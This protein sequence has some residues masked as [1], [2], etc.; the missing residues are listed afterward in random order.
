MTNKDDKKALNQMGL[1]F[2]EEVHAGDKFEF[3]YGIDGISSHETRM[4]SSKE[5]M[6]TEKRNSVGKR[7]GGEMT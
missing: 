3:V 6:Y 4:R 1:E 5:E 7:Y 2:R